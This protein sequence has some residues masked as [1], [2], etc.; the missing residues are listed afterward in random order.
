MRL[1]ALFLAVFACSCAAS[2]PEPGTT[3]QISADPPQKEESQHVQQLPRHE[4]D[5][6]E[7]SSTRGKHRAVMRAE[8]ERGIQLS[9][10]AISTCGISFE[11]IRFDKGRASIDPHSIVHHGFEREIY[12]R[13]G[14]WI[15]PYSV[16]ILNRENG[17]L[18]VSVPDAPASADIVHRR[19]NI[20]RLAYR[21]AFGA[22]GS[23]HG[24]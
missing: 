1:G 2:A 17:R 8:P 5:S 3:D 19:A 21:E 12:L 14:N 22:S 16:E 23:G 7:H 18:E 9:D 10:V 15:R 24:H 11:P 20:V 6:H 13:S 4:L